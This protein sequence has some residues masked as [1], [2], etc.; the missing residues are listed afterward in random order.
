VKSEFYAWCIE[1]TRVEAFGAALSALAAGGRIRDL[2]TSIGK[3]YE[4]LSVEETVVAERGAFMG[5]SSDNVYFEVTLPSRRTLDGHMVIYGDRDIR[6]RAHPAL[7]ICAFEDH[8]EPQELLPSR[9]SVAPGRDHRSIEAEAALAFLVAEPDVEDLLVRLCASPHVTTGACS[10]DDG[11]DAPIESAATYHADAA[12]VARDLALS[13]AH[14]HERVE[15]ERVVGLPL[16]ALRARVEA[17]PQGASVAVATVEHLAQERHEHRLFRAAHTEPNLRWGYL[18]LFPRVG[19]PG[20]DELTR[21]QVLAAMST[22]PTKLLEALE[23]A[24]AALTDDAWRT[25]ERPARARWAATIEGAP[26]SEVDVS[27]PEHRRFLQEHAPFH[28]RRLPNGGLL[29]ATHPY[30]TLWPLWSAALARLGIR[31]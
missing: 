15:V 28:V 6:G 2:Y 4:S 1:A 7:N 5:Q 26:T 31:S 30:R 18:P 14:L 23:A 19:R 24:A 8:Y 21:E 27:T 29:L 25:A 16:D 9:L 11:W 22:P 3:D 13:W 20:E 12:A 17:A 10:G